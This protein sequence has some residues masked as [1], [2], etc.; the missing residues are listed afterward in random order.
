MNKTAFL[1]AAAVL[2]LSAGAGSAA[3]SHLAVAHKGF[4][5]AHALVAPNKHVVTL[6]D[7]N[8]NDAGASVLSANFESSFEAYDSQG[9]DDFVVPDGH[10]WKVTGV[11]VTGAYFN[12]TGPASGV[13]VSFYKDN[14]GLPGDLVK[15]MGA[16]KFT[17]D[18]GSFAVRLQDAVPLKAGTYWVSVQATMDASS[19]AGEWGWEV[20]SVQNGN[21]AAWQN[22]GGAFGVCPSWASVQSCTGN[23]PDFMFSLTGKDKAKK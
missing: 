1:A 21:M 8:A 22:P 3:N 9:A 10:K 4:A 6:Y 23:G 2:A 19:G 15:T 11:T 5:K 13:V 12:G 18:A 14:A 17:D 20:N 16:S 7:Q